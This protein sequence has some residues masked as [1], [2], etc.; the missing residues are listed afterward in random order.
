MKGGFRSHM[1]ASRIG[2]LRLR[3]LWLSALVAAFAAGGHAAQAQERL[4]EGGPA[5][6]ESFT[7]DARIALHSL[8]SLSDAYLQKMA[9]VLTVLTTTDEA[10]SA[11]WERI[12]V[13]L[14]RA[15][16]TN[17]PATV[18]FALPDGGYWTVG[19]GRAAANLS[20]RPYFPRVLAGQTIIGELV[21]SRATGESSAIVAVPVRQEGGEVVAVLGA[22]VHLDSLSELI[23]QQMTVERDQL[24]FSLDA[25]AVVGLHIDPEII[26]LH[27]LEEGDPDLERAIREIL[28]REQGA[29]SYDFRGKRRTVLYRHSPVTDWWYAFGVLHQ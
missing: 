14:T 11:E 21:V 28:S 22:S 1:D 16:E 17:V 8:V 19:E 12:R 5:A 20:D 29:V 10:R 13:P 24:F 4:A 27:P 9:D 25:E 15:A 6:A 7:V 2:R 3:H 23:M 26:L 18:W